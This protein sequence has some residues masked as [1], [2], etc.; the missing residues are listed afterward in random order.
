MPTMKERLASASRVNPEYRKALTPEQI[1]KPPCRWFHKWDRVDDPDAEWSA[2]YQCRKCH[3]R[4]A[5]TLGRG[6]YTAPDFCW[7]D[8]KAWG[9]I[10][11]VPTASSGLSRAKAPPKSV[12]PTPTPRLDRIVEGMRLSDASIPP[13]LRPPTADD[14]IR[15]VRDR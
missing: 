12:I 7:L 5:V 6:S 14:M 10:P 1:A 2:H 4:K 9:F 13:P 8:G 11:P 3:D 15:T